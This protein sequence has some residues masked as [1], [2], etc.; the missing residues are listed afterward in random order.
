MLV[1]ALLATLSAHAGAWTAEDLVTAHARG[2]PDATVTR[3]AESVGLDDTTALYLLR[4]GVPAAAV[5]AWGHPV[6]E[7]VGIDA[8]RLGALDAPATGVSDTDWHEM[9]ELPAAVER[10]DGTV[11]GGEP[12]V[13]LPERAVLLDRRKPCAP[14]VVEREDAKDVWVDAAPIGYTMRAEL[15]W[16][17]TEAGPHHDER[18]ARLTRRGN[19]NI[20]VGALLA[21]A[22]GV[23]FAMGARADSTYGSLGPPAPDP[24]VMGL[25]AVGLLAGGVTLHFGARQLE[26]AGPDRVAWTT[27]LL[28]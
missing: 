27:A 7:A 25:G 8:T 15:A 18:R 16:I 26:L 21:V 20:G 2:L 5:R 17:E 1:V 3:M 12:V 24:V 13:V 23:T 14:A 9:T 4:R 28:E 11:A 22:G 10:A 6:S 19:R